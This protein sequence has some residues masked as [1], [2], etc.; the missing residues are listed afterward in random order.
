MK[1]LPISLNRRF[2]W[3]ECWLCINMLLKYNRQPW[4]LYYFFCTHL[5]LSFVWITLLLFR[6][7]LCYHADEREAVKCGLLWLGY[8]NCALFLLNKDGAI[9]KDSST[10]RYGKMLLSR[11]NAEEHLYQ[12]YKQ[13][14]NS[15]LKNTNG[16]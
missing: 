11:V 12:L 16:F 7:K 4:F 14:Q 6:Y 15:K 10:V 3:K 2:L 5:L 9:Q 8:L 1:R 13:C